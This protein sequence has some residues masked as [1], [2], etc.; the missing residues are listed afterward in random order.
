[1]ISSQ[2]VPAF[3]TALCLFLAFGAVLGEKLRVVSILVNLWFEIANNISI[4]ID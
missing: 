1:M 2:R 3:V 4:R